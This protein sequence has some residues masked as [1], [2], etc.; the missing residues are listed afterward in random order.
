LEAGQIEALAEEFAS[1]QK[2][3]AIWAIGQAFNVNSAYDHLAFAALN[4][5]KGNLKPNGLVSLAPAVPL[6]GLPPVQKDPG[7]DESAGPPGLDVVRSGSAP[8]RRY[9]FYE[10]LD[11]VREGSKCSVEMLLVHEANP[12]YS[13]PENKLFE[14]ALEKVPTL[15]S[16]SSYMDETAAKADLILP[17]HTAFE[18][19]VDVVGIPCAPF[20]YYALGAPVMKPLLDTR[21]TGEVL[22][23]LA[24]SVGAPV[25]ESMPWKSYEEYLR[26][27]VQGIA[28]SRKGAIADKPDVPIIKLSSAQS[29]QPNYSSGEELWKKLKSGCCWYDAPSPVAGFETA[30]GKFELACR[31]IGAEGALGDDKLYLPHF[32]PAELSGSESEYPLLLVAYKPSYTTVGYL[33]TPSFMNKL[34]PDKVLQGGDIL[35]E[36]HPQTAAEL[37]FAHGQRVFLKTTQGGAAVRV[38]IS[39]AARPGVVYMPQGLGHWAYDLYVR[40]KGANANSLMEVQLDPVGLMGTL[41]P[42]RAQL[43]SE[44]RGNL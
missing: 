25:R 29:V 19:Y 42:C 30:S 27:R 5:L 31:S 2:A 22:L 16:F 20:S 17:D 39:E 18:R 26:F 3:L 21:H 9:G 12:L 8:Y 11:D 1:R 24:G 34:I 36:L 41:L 32:A 37:K 44:E 38:N 23:R 14:Q 40:G 43:R 35:I 4:A 13:I 33:P 6:A 28:Q 7:A 10:F 15:V